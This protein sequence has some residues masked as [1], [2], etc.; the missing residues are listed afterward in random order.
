[1]ALLLQYDKE[2]EVMV[3]CQ[4]CG[5]RFLYQADSDYYDY[6]DFVRDFHTHVEDCN[7]V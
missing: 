2:I 6:I 7:G 3:R 1:M 5:D 4:F